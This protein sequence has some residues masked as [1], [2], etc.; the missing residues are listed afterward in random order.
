MYRGLIKKQDDILSDDGKCQKQ[1]ETFISVLNLNVS[2]DCV[3]INLT[4]HRL[5]F[6]TDTAHPTSRG[7]LLP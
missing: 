6:S 1:T 7:L 2:G 5:R 4:T 3:T